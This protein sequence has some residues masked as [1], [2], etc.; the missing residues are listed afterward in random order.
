MVKYRIY[1][2]DGEFRGGLFKA[3][4]FTRN[5]CRVWDG[6]IVG[7]YGEI[8]YDIGDGN[9]YL[10]QLAQ[11]PDYERDA[12]GKIIFDYNSRA[13]HLS[14]AEAADWFNNQVHR[15]PKYL[16]K[17]V[18]EFED[19][20]N[21]H[22]YMDK[23]FSEELGLSNGDPAQSHDSKGASSK[24]QPLPLSRK[25]AFSLYE[26]ATKLNPCLTTDLE[27]YDWLRDFSDIPKELEDTLQLPFA[28]FRRYLSHARKYYDKN[29]N[30]PR[31]GRPARGC[32]IRQN[33]K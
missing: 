31:H 14:P 19:V 2:S 16:L 24:S 26:Y 1:D 17:Q 29:K 9:W 13:I 8:M 3:E 25:K 27:V 15:A 23:I 22:E 18:K 6:R 33:E 12:G 11:T 21:Y 10:L 30:N 28:S 4:S 5:N 20:E 7:D 32:I